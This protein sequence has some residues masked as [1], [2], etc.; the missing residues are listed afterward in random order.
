MAGPPS[1]GDGSSPG[2]RIA[3][4]RGLAKSLWFAAGTL[5]LAIGLVGVAVP[6]LPTTPFLLLAAACYLRSSK[7]M[8]DWMMTNKIFGRYLREYHEGRGVPVRVKVGTIA[9]LWIVISITAVFFV[10]ELWLRALLVI[11]AIAVS[12]HIATIRPRKQTG[13]DAVA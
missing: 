4:A 2:C 9:F 3:E 8:Y 13:Q 7:R 1:E 12:L 10:D 6:I 11:I 5:F